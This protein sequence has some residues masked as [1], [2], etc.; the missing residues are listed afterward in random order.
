[1]AQWSLLHRNWEKSNYLG[2][3]RNSKYTMKLA[4]AFVSKRDHTERSSTKQRQRTRSRVQSFVFCFGSENFVKKRV[5]LIGTLLG[6]RVFLEDND[7][8][9]I[10]PPKVS[11]S[12]QLEKKNCLEKFPAP[13]KTYFALKNLISRPPALRRTHAHTLCLQLP[14]L[15]S[16][17]L[18]LSPNLPVPLSVSLMCLFL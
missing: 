15:P 6:L 17:S 1:M 12:S 14:S 3:N 5:L 11:R 13:T 4:P 2:D 8:D 10:W 7:D 9:E 16:P 18:P